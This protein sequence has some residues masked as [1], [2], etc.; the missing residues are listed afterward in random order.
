MAIEDA[1]ATIKFILSGNTKAY[2]PQC[3]LIPTPILAKNMYHFLEDDNI[4][5]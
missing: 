2:F 1:R 5:K 3:Q 4:K